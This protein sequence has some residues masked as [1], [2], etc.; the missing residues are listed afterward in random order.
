MDNIFVVVLIGFY[1][2]VAGYFL[3]RYRNLMTSTRR[4]LALVV[5][6]SLFILAWFVRFLSLLSQRPPGLFH[7]ALLAVGA[8]ACL[9]LVLQGVRDHKRETGGGAG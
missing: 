1:I 9:P 7:S 4:Y 8:V 6:T 3:L 5:P 2:L